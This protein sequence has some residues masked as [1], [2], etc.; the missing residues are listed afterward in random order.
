MVTWLTA[1]FPS[2]N[3]QSETIT[4]SDGHIEGAEQNEMRHLSRGPSKSSYLNSFTAIQ[5]DKEFQ[6]RFSHI[7][8]LEMNSHCCILD[9]KNQRK[10]FRDHP[11]RQFTHPYSM[12][13]FFRTDNP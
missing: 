4:H 5:M 1:I 10:H 12:E 6:R 3:S 2:I 9:L 11:F 8:Q 13:N 7:R